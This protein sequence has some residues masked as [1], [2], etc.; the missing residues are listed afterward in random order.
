MDVP[1]EAAAAVLELDA[2]AGPLE[3]YRVQTRLSEIRAGFAPTDPRHRGAWVAIVPFAVATKAEAQDPLHLYFGPMGSRLGG[4]GTVIYSPDLRE[5]EPEGFEYWKDQLAAVRHP[6]LVARYADILWETAPVVGRVRRDAAHARMAVRAYLTAASDAL[7]ADGFDETEGLI[8]AASLS[9]SLRDQD[10]ILAA[11]KRLLSLQGRTDQPGYFDIVEKL[12][13]TPALGLDDIEQQQVVDLLV[14]RFERA[15]NSTP[16]SFDPFEAEICAEHLLRF[17]RRHGEG[18]R[19]RKLLRSL[20]GAFE[21]LANMA[22]PMVAAA[23]L[24][25]AMEAYGNAGATDDVKRLRI[26]KEQAVRDSVANM[27]HFEHRIEIKKTDLDEFLDLLVDDE[28]EMSFARTAARFVD[29]VETIRQRVLRTSKSSPIQSFI[30]ITIM[31]DEHVAATVGSV[32]EDMDGRV[33]W[34]TGKSRSVDDVFLDRGLERLIERHRLGAADIVGW[35]N[36]LGAFPEN[37]YLLYE[38][39][40]AWMLGDWSKCLH[41]LVPQIEAGLRNVLRS[42]GSPTVKSHTS[43]G[44]REIMLNLGEILAAPAMAEALGPDLIL[45]FRSVYSDPRAWNLRNIVAHGLVAPG[46]ASSRRCNV[47]LHSLLVLGCWRDIAA[48]RVM[49]DATP[50]GDTTA[51]EH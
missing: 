5:V 16:G 10:L 8:R 36:R 17:F 13:G 43:G 33:M 28:L 1:S 3:L 37:T 40:R 39:V 26:Q 35:A 29:R 38:G 30:T 9:C 24:D 15:T 7:F 45:Y 2:T 11:K 44:G 49:M 48:S 25:N 31:E 27:G 23:H 47:L 6:V 18:Q 14:A 41:V 22:D 4:D 51:G 12:L 34:E 19:A 32:D 42:L 21:Q 46:H 20:G 50:H